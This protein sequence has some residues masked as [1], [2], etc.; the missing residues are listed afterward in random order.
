MKDRPK[1]YLVIDPDNVTVGV[2]WERAD[3]EK[4]ATDRTT[5]VQKMSGGYVD[6]HLVEEWQVL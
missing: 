2:F 4:E 6:T 5:Y 1:I 3:A